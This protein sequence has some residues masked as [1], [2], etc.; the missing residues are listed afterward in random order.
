[1]DNYYYCWYPMRVLPYQV[2]TPS[3]TMS[4]CQCGL[5][6]GQPAARLFATSLT[7]EQELIH[8]QYKGGIS[9][10]EDFYPETLTANFIAPEAAAVMIFGIWIHPKAYRKGSVYFGFYEKVK[11][12]PPIAGRLLDSSL[13]EVIELDPYSPLV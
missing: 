2:L 7:A 8:T 10:E 3:L 11:R 5:G 1:M 6:N 9:M 4:G 13:N 12:T